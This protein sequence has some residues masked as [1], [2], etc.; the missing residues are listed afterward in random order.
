MRLPP[1]AKS[2]TS[3]G[4]GRCRETTL[5]LPG[6]LRVAPAG[7]EMRADR[8]WAGSSGPWPDLGTRRRRHGCQTEARLGALDITK[9]SRRRHTKRALCAG[10][11][12]LDFL[13]LA[14]V[15]RRRSSTAARTIRKKAGEGRR[16]PAGPAL[17]A[18]PSSAGRPSLHGP[19][20]ARADPDVV[21]FQI[22]SQD[23][24][25]PDLLHRGELRGA[26]Q[27]TKRPDGPESEIAFSAI[28]SDHR[29]LERPSLRS[30]G[31]RRSP[32]TA[33]GRLR[34]RLRRNREGLR[35]ATTWAPTATA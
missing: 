20:T 32:R 1:S 11:E 6:G 26:Q 15:G 30:L 25:A 16:H 14:R 35:A 13:E 10:L 24:S 29:L 23:E 33:N 28:I 21:E 22:M 18:D 8:A 34:E 17:P 19:A 2:T 4:S 12:S 9:T 7:L 31:L 27:A 5:S 3:R